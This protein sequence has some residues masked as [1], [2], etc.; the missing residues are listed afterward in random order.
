MIITVQSHEAQNRLD[1]FLAEKTEDLTRS[2]I[3]KLISEGCVA[4]NGETPKANCRLK[5]GDVIE[6][7]M[8]TAKECE[9]EAEEIPLDIVY[10]DSDML[11]V[12]KPQGM[13]VHPAAGNY[14]GTLVNALMA[15]CG[16][17]LSGINGEIRPGILHRIDK[18]TSGL[19]MVAKNDIAHSKLS[20]QIKEHSLT[21]EYLALVHGNIKEDSGT[22]DAPI[23]RDEK[24]RKKM[25]ITQKNSRNAV[26]HFFVEER[27]N[28][29]TLIRC[30]LETGRTHQIRVHMSKNGHPIVGDK[31]YGV[32]K[33]EFKLEG[34][35]L[36]ARKIG[37][38]HPRNNEYM[39]F[40]REAPE[41]FNKVIDK[42]RREKHVKS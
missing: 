26:T 29:Y 13:V 39:E 16:D 8:P 37:F 1:V 19:L 11:V 18:D 34:Q 21:R 35:L 28:K 3:Q 38:I 4:L 30:R 36:H 2:R 40:E 7:N 31:T 20:E 10:E 33:E 24:N 15:Y 9:I 17:S 25:T 32:K 22:I 42:L 14:S 41:Y 27:F 5:E 12:N 23:G 6:I